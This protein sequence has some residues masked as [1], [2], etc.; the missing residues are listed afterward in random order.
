M[1]VENLSHDAANEAYTLI[2]AYIREDKISADYDKH[3]LKEFAIFLSD[4]LKHPGN[5]TVKVEEEESSSES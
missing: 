5:F 1:L 3:Y 2:M 4:V